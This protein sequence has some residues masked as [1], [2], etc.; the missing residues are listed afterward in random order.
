MKK[1]FAPSMQGRSLNF[2]AV[3]PCFNAENGV[4]ACSVTGAT[5]RVSAFPCVLGSRDAPF[6]KRMSC[7]R[8]HAF[9]RMACG[10]ILLLRTCLFYPFRCKMA[11]VKQKIFRRFTTLCPDKVCPIRLSPVTYSLICQVGVSKTF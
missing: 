11:I 3:P 2:F 9:W 10:R 6:A 8:E 1:S 7:S 5:G 4:L